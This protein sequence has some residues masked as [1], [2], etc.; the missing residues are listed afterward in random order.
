MKPY[1]VLS[2]G[3]KFR[4]DLSRQIRNGALIDEYTSVVNRAC[5]KSASRALSKYI[6]KNNIKI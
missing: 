2:N 1:K 6:R 3:E 5:A 4:A